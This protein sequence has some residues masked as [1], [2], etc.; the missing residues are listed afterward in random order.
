MQQKMAT[1]LELGKAQLISKKREPEQ[2]KKRDRERDASGRARWGFKGRELLIPERKMA[3]KKLREGA[4]R[5]QWP[6]N[7]SEQVKTDPSSW[8]FTLAAI[9][10]GMG[11]DGQETPR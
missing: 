3:G 1:L 7:G 2:K 10:L 4:G 5:A 9:A 8:R 6:G 11:T